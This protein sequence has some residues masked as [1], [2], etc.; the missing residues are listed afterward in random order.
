ME[1]GSGIMCQENGFSPTP[2]RRDLAHMASPTHI[3]R[4]LEKLGEKEG[5]SLDHLGFSVISD[6]IDSHYISQRYLYD[7]YRQALKKEMNKE[8]KHQARRHYLDI[9]AKHA[10]YKSFEHFSKT[11]R[12]EIPANALACIGNWWSYVRVNLGEAVLK[13]PV[14]IFQ[15]T[16]SQKLFME[17][18]GQERIFKG[19]LKIEAN[20]ISG[21]LESGTTKWLGLI[22][23]LGAT[24]K[25][26]L[27][28][29][30]FCGISSAN[31][32]IAGRELLVRE[33]GLS[34][35][36]MTW[37][38][39]SPKDK[40]LPAQLQRYFHDRRDNCINIVSPTVYDKADLP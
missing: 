9:L 6:Q 12:V 38:K 13:A 37:K 23:K 22:F 33:P 19:E 5:Q 34:Y 31:T 10:G 21:A 20:C 8:T 36:E 35:E 11:L 28:Q 14:R 16:Y 25:I 40:E 32:P 1:F 39:L 18:R 29:G 17:L 30:V 24:Q 15:D 4:L 26:N 3:L 7:L 2:V 27:L